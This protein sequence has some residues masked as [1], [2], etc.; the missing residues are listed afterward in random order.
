MVAGSSPHPGM[1][2]SQSV[3]PGTMQPGGVLPLPAMSLAMPLPA[4]TAPLQLQQQL[5]VQQLQQQ[6]LPVV[7]QLQ[8]QLP[9]HQF[10]QPMHPGGAHQQQQ[11][12]QGMLYPH[13]PAF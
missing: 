6:Q 10:M 5:P 4:M 13:G 7:Q 9:S 11:Q 2:M 8:Q 12:Q 1:L 3:L